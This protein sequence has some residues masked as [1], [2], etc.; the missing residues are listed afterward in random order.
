MDAEGLVHLR[1]GGVSLVVDTRGSGLP[2]VLHWGADLGALDAADLLA[3]SAVSIPPTGFGP[4]DQVVPLSIV[5]EQSAGWL[6]T[7]GLSGH[8]AGRDFSARFVTERV[9]SEQGSG[10]IAHR[11]TISAV[12]EHGR[13]GISLEIEMAVSGLVRLR[14]TLSN[15]DPGL[16]YTLDGLLLTLPVPLRAQEILDFSGR[17]LRERSPQRHTFTQG[18]HQR[19]NRRGRTGGDATLLLL[20]GARPSPSSTARSG[21]CTSPG[22]AITGLSRSAIPTAS[23]C[24][25]AVSCSSRAR[26]RSRRGSRTPRRGSSAAGAAA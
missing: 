23:A 2:R 24:S 12:D 13:L 20:A 11:L 8:R 14:A 6:G 4:V 15:D 7:P 18:T 26:A 17:H 21:D 9:E 1:A 25:A 19:D 3:L 10:P 5:P 16:D 22:A